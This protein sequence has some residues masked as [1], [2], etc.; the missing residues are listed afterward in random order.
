MYISVESEYFSS[1]LNFDISEFK[2]NID[3]FSQKELMFLQSIINNALNGI[4]KKELDKRNF[5]LYTQ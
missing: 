2:R 3:L 4:D 5:F 1:I